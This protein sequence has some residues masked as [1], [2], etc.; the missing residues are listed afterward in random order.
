MSEHTQ[1]A[2][3]LCR[4]GLYTVSEPSF[5]FPFLGIASQCAPVLMLKQT[6]ACDVAARPVDRGDGSVVRRW[7]VCV[8]VCVCACVL[9][10]ASVPW[11][12][13]GESSAAGR[14][15]GFHSVKVEQGGQGC[16]I[17]MDSEYKN[18]RLGSYS[19]ICPEKKLW[20]RTT[21]MF[22]LFFF[23]RR[24]SRERIAKP[25]IIFATDSVVFIILV[26]LICAAV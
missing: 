20:C 9:G 17:Q 22:F 21:S 1:L 11:S 23:K 25:V 19:F 14:G 7:S 26:P 16:N 10:G 5:F 24:L 13:N 6:V 15:G 18:K 3:A 2:V 12:V 8:C 4:I